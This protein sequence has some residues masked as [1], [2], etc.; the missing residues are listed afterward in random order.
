MINMS[1]YIVRLIDT[2][3]LVGFLVADTTKDLFWSIDELLNPHECEYKRITGGG[4]FW[5]ESGAG[6]M[7][8]TIPV[9]DFEEYFELP[10]LDGASLA[11]WTQREYEDERPWK[12]FKADAGYTKTGEGA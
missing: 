3:E 9:E 2:D 6:E 12:R 5:G 4:I 11:Q 1:A 8:P 7:Y 10:P